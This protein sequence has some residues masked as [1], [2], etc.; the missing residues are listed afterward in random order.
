MCTAKASSEQGME[1]AF[2]NSLQLWFPAQDLYRVDCQHFILVSGEGFLRLHPS[3][4][5]YWQM[6]EEEGYQKNTQNQKSNVSWNGE[7]CL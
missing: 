2:M 1:I 5:I 4:R 7:I 3:L 6:L